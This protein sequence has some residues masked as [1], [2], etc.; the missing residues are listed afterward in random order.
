M[1]ANEALEAA[2]LKL[3]RLHGNKVYMAAW[4]RAAKI[5]RSLKT[6]TNNENTKNASLPKS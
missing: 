6:N 4:R 3:E 5:I 2:A 1:T